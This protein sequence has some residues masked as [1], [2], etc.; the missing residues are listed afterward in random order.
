M[1]ILS[2]VSALFGCLTLAATAVPSSTPLLPLSNNSPCLTLSN[3]SGPDLSPTQFTTGQK[4]KQN[5]AKALSPI[6]AKCSAAL[7]TNGRYQSK[8]PQS[9]TNLRVLRYFEKATATLPH[10]TLAT[11]SAYDKPT[12]Y[13][14][15]PQ[16]YTNMRKLKPCETKLLCASGLL[17][18]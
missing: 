5:S 10:R 14:K 6:S 12:N 4:H 16:N 2:L 3:V 18:S 8:L 1:I 17:P 11:L 7:L 15:R 9:F 13:Y